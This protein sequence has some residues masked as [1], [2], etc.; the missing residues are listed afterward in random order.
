MERLSI[1]AINGA[2]PALIRQLQ[3]AGLTIDDLSEPGR[4]FF[5]FD[6]PEQGLI[7]FIGWEAAAGEPVAL[8]RSLGVWS[9]LDPQR[10]N[11][12][13]RMRVLPAASAAAPRASPPPDAAGSGSTDPADEEGQGKRQREGC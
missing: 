11:P 13:Q 2:D 5:R 8:L 4:C 12:V 7:V 3:Q 6:H 10:A 1:S 9:A